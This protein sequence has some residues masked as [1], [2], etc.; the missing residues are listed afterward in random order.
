MKKI[1]ATLLVSASIASPF[2]AQ[3]QAPVVVGALGSGLAS[4]VVLVL[5]ATAVIATVSSA[6]NH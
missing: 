2:A 4:T 3:A 6:S 1:I 5:S